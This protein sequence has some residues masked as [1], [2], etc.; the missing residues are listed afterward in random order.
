MRRDQFDSNPEVHDTSLSTGFESE[1][2]IGIDE[3][4]NVT[5]LTPVLASG[6][7]VLTCTPTT[8]SWSETV[9]VSGGYRYG[10]TGSL[11]TDPIQIDTTTVAG[12]C[13][14]VDGV[15]GISG[16]NSFNASVTTSISAT[17]AQDAPT[18]VSCPAC[19]PTTYSYIPNTSANTVFL[20]PDTSISIHA[21]TPLMGA[22]SIVTTWDCLDPGHTS[23]GGTATSTP[24]STTCA[25]KRSV[26][27]ITESIAN[28]PASPQPS[29]PFP[30][31][32]G[33]TPGT[34]VSCT[35][36]ASAQL[37]WPSLPTCAPNGI[38]LAYDVTYPLRH[39]KAFVDTVTGDLNT[40]FASNA[41]TPLMW[42][43]TDTGINGVVMLR[44]RWRKLGAKR[45]IT[46]F[47]SLS[48]SGP[49]YYAESSDEGKT[50]GTPVNITS[51]ATYWALDFEWT[52]SGLLYLYWSESDGNIYRAVYDNSLN[53]RKTRAATNISGVI[54]APIACRESKKGTG[55]W[56]IGLLYT[57][58]GGLEF[59]TA[60]DGVT[61]S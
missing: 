22:Q 60:Q 55:G 56:R 24:S 31:T 16:T 58:S 57:D 26:T 41:P 18:T 21:Q 44:L 36:N 48:A 29:C 20:N 52:A 42:T 49:L 43:D 2:L 17:V 37:L 46:A 54:N 3:R 25:S 13:S 47:Y 11:A 15:A 23:G 33:P 35:Y 10:P 32:C 45:L 51:G 30:V 7:N 6:V 50:F 40:S 53:S 8:G 27:Q 39:V 1:P 4:L 59:E 61:F 19:S 5:T 12:T 14:C 38:A 28:C 9:T 34:L